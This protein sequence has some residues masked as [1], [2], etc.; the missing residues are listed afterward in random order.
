LRCRLSSPSLLSP[1]LHEV[2]KM[3]D[4]AA[5]T[6]PLCRGDFDRRALIFFSFLGWHHIKR[7]FSSFFPLFLLRHKKPS[8][9]RLLFFHGVSPC[10]TRTNMR[11]D[12]FFFPSLSFSPRVYPPGCSSPMEPVLPFPSLNK[13]PS[14]SKT[15]D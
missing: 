13:G 12:G 9:F 10:L 8:Q 6:P 11:A 5:Y 14:P 7:S 1:P 15:K 4:P 2:V 3:F